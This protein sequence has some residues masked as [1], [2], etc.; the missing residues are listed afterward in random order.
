MART[1]RAY[2]DLGHVLYR[3]MASDV[4][5][6]RVGTKQPFAAWLEHGV[7]CMGRCPLCRDG[8]RDQKART[9]KQKMVR[10]LLK[11]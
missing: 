3:H 10:L 7:V 4:L 1:R 9:E 2:N 11:E 5:V 6:E 8:K